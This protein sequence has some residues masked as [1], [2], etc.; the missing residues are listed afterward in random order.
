[1][2]IPHGYYTGLVINGMIALALSIAMWRITENF[3]AWLVLALPGGALTIYGTI[4]L[5]SGYE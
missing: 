2:Q 1:M 4:M 5:F 3:W